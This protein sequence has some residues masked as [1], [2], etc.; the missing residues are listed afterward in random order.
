MRLSVCYI[1]NKLHFHAVDTTVHIQ[2]RA[3]LLPHKTN[4]LATTSTPPGYRLQT[5]ERRRCLPLVLPVPG[6]VD[7]RAPCVGVPQCIALETREM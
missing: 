3:D 5:G 4:L 7:V 1:P 6:P 2:L